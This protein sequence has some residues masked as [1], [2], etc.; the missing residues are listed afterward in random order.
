MQTFKDINQLV[1]AYKIN[2]IAQS[3]SPKKEPLFEIR[4]MQMR[5]LFDEFMGIVHEFIERGDYLSTARGTLEWLDL[6]YRLLDIEQKMISIIGEANY[7]K[8]D[9][10]TRWIIEFAVDSVIELIQR[11]QKWLR[12]Q[13]GIFRKVKRE[14][15]SLRPSVLVVLSELEFS[16][17]SIIFAIIKVEAKESKPQEL[18]RVVGQT[19]HRAKHFR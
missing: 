4:D 14:L 12:K 11:T 17:F 10:D 13:A 15:P 9:E 3:F 18:Y 8:Y 5:R 7:P 16:I 2:N 1:K 6:T 19:L